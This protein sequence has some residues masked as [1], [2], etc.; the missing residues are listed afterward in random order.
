MLT[1]VAKSFTENAQATN[2]EATDSDFRL[3]EFPD[4]PLSLI[5]NH[6]RELPMHD[7][8]ALLATCKS[9][10]STF[11]GLTGRMERLQLTLGATPELDSLKQHAA[12]H[13]RHGAFSG[14]H[15]ALKV[16]SWFPGTLFVG[17]LALQFPVGCAGSPSLRSFAVSAR[18]WLMHITSLEL[19]AANSEVRAACNRI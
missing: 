9:A 5:W 14:G 6:A 3:L 1:L 16:L 11:A 4:L 17:R 7:R 18:M 13:P 8:R 10:L 2:A 19:N 12:A 15:H